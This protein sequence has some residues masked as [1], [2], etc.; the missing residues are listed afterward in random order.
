[1]GDD[2]LREDSDECSFLQLP[3]LECDPS[4]MRMPGAEAD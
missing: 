2:F 3:I 1:M 4:E